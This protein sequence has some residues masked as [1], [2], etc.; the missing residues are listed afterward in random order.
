MA[1]E[2]GL[3]K[4]ATPGRR[5]RCGDS[6]TP[7]HYG[8][9]ARNS[10]RANSCP[11]SGSGAGYEDGALENPGIASAGSRWNREDGAHHVAGAAEG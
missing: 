2:Q 6:A 10:R 3:E 9:R 7:V 1:M 4:R 5:G 11:D 8:D